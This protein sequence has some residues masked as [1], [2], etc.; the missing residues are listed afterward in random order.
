MPDEYVRVSDQIRSECGKSSGFL[1]KPRRRPFEIRKEIR[2][3]AL[4]QFGV[5]SPVLV[6]PVEN[7]R[8][9]RRDR[10]DVPVGRD[11][12]GPRGVSVS[13]S[14]ASSARARPA[15]ESVSSMLARAA[16]SVRIRCAVVE[17]RMTITWAASRKILSRSAVPSAVI[18]RT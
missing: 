13:A 1:Q 9:R 15:I 11:Q 6:E 18:W 5:E 7:P 10:L 17:P 3:A 4:Q 16:M 14:P 2:P 12:H 8:P